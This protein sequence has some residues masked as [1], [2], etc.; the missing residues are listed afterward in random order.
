ML[1]PRNNKVPGILSIHAP[2][3]S[4][5]TRAPDKRNTEDDSKI[6][7]LFL[8]KNIICDPSLEPSQRDG[9]NDGSQNMF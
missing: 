4:L 3:L 5:K 9:S 6:I 8:N 2:T 1:L 7:F